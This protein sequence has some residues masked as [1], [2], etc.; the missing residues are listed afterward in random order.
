MVS[1]RTSPDF[2]KSDAQGVTSYHNRALYVR[3]YIREVELRCTMVDTESSL[4]IIPLSM[5]GVSRDRIVKKPNTVSCFK[6]T[7]SFTICH[8]KLE[9]TIVRPIR[10]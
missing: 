5:T 10:G 7:S 8:I 4:N 2:Y 3:A 6:G 9:L 1:S